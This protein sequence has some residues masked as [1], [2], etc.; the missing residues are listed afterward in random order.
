MDY[1]IN[2][3]FIDGMVYSLLSWAL[4]D[5]ISVFFFF[6]MWTI[7]EVLI[8]FFTILFLFYVLVSWTRGL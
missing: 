5:F 6:L 2:V 8:E 4:L 1:T 7:F 3:L